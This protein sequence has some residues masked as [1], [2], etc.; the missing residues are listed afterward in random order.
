[1]ARMGK[2]CSCLC[3]QP[4]HCAGWALQL[5]LRRLIEAACVQHQLPCHLSRNGL[6]ILGSLAMQSAAPVTD[7][8]TYPAGGHGIAWDGPFNPELRRLIEAAYLQKK[9]IAAVDH[10]PA[11]LVQALNRD[12]DDPAYGQ[13]IIY[14]KQV[15]PRC[16]SGNP[17]IPSSG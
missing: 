12:Q 9:L 6:D 4:W 2:H 8:A 10:G 11:A 16:A 14:H 15:S 1:M 7:L 5:Q 17:L 13:S 3:M